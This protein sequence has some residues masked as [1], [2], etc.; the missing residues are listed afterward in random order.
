MNIE[1][2]TKALVKLPR[3]DH[4]AT[5]TKEW[6]YPASNT[7]DIADPAVQEFAYHLRIAVPNNITAMN[8]GAKADAK[9]LVSAHPN[10]RKF[11]VLE[12]RAFHSPDQLRAAASR[13]VKA[14]PELP[15][16]WVGSRGAAPEPEVKAPAKKAAA[17]KTAA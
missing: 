15:A 5:L 1:A 11:P 13:W 17:K 16:P 8:F 10:G 14:H 9:N 3:K 7:L 12:G 6:S 2:L 4:G